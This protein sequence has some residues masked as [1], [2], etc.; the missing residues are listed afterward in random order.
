M[1]YIKL[2]LVLLFCSVERSRSDK[3]TTASGNSSSCDT[4]H[5]LHLYPA[6]IADNV[7]IGWD[8]GLEMIPAGRI[9][10]NQINNR[11]DI[12]QNYKL[13]II[14]I[15]SEDCG[16]TLIVKGIVGLYKEMV[17][18]KKTCVFGVVG[19]YCSTVTNDTVPLVNHARIGHV[20]L[21]SSTSPRHRDTEK[22]PYLFHTVAS[23][24]VYNQA[25]L[26]MMKEF[27]WTRINLVN[28]FRNF[29]CQTTSNDFLDRII[30]DTRK[31][32]VTRIPVSPQ[33]DSISKMFSEIRLK[34][35]RIT[36]YSIA[37]TEVSRI[38]CTAYKNK[39]LWPEYVYILHDYNI[40]WI[41]SFLPKANFCTKEEIFE[42][43]EGVFL[44]AYRL[45]PFNETRLISGMTYSQ[46][47]TEYKEEVAKFANETGMELEDNLY[48]NT[49][50]DQVWAFALAANRSLDKV[51]YRKSSVSDQSI[52]EQTEIRETLAR[53]LKNVSFHGA[54]GFIRFGKEQEAQ[55]SV[56]IF[57]VHKG[58]MILIGIYN[59]YN[60]TIEFTKNF[61]KS[62]LPEDTFS[63]LF[64]EV[65]E[66]LGI[67]VISCDVVLF[68]LILFNTICMIFWRKRPEI[69]STSISLSLLIQ[70]GCFLMCFSIIFTTLLEKIG[71]ETALDIFC[72]L[73][74]WLSI[75]GA[76]IIFVT[77]FFRLLRIFHIFRSYRPIGK[78]WSDKYLIIYISL[79]CSLPVAVLVVWTG[80][81]PVHQIMNHIIFNHLPYFY[82]VC[83]SHSQDVFLA[84]SFS[85]ITIV[86]ILIIFL[87]I[88]TRHIKRKHYK[89]TKK[90]IMFVFSLC[91]VIP[92]S[93]ILW[94]MFIELQ[95]ITLS[96]IFHCITI[97]AVVFL[98]QIFLFLPKILPIIFCS[99][100]KVTRK[101]RKTS[102][103]S[104]LS[105]FSMK[106]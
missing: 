27:N 7:T 54:T 30:N 39:F 64:R 97:L 68:I 13:E 70:I 104:M 22:Y 89:D 24:K 78:G 92:V 85:L 81:D 67:V 28:D 51:D 21:A 55:T 38:F 18:P 65:P 106:L 45:H 93:G 42:A 94:L 33:K 31:E 98:C 71:N 14:D 91:I 87:S 80:V 53:E 9:A 41:E 37:Q 102:N 60:K 52:K 69:K 105:L 83:T 75:D 103:S 61:S 5:L 35:A 100:K 76:N 59:S 11:S 96:F 17:D 8:K 47:Y 19:L 36:Y 58:E 79:V 95:L 84:I 29:Y 57:Q 101:L 25:V 3:I 26:T 90:M 44:I 12:L 73:E 6:P 46:Y 99:R 15:P 82:R 32:L 74:L 23:T 48:A 72:H 20:Q 66:W 56:N 4:L 10:V 40:D 62:T 88:R 1:K 43:L 50:Y 63:K 49:F 77:I 34:G 16:K 86:I 2:L